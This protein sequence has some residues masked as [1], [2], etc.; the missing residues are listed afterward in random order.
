[1]FSVH[2]TQASSP[3]A[4]TSTLE[5]VKLISAVLPKIVSHDARTADQP[6][7]SG[8]P[9][10]MHLTCSPCDQTRSISWMSS[11]SNAR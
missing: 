5:S 10:W 1:M 2:V 7:S 6:T 4:T 9:G 11:V 8:Q 3:T